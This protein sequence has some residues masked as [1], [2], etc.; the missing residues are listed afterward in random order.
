MNPDL[1]LRPDAMAI[2][3]VI[4]LLSVLMAALYTL[5]TSRLIK[6]VRGD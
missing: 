3:G 5:L 2:Y 1:K 6:K 4:L